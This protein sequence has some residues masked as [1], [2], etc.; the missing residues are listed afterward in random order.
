M[1]H[2]R[3]P[4]PAH[5]ARRS[6]RRSIPPRRRSGT[7]RL[8]T[9]DAGATLDQ[10]ATLVPLRRDAHD[11]PNVFDD[12]ANWWALARQCMV[13]L[14]RCMRS[15]SSTSTSSRTTS[16]FPARP[17]QAARPAAGQPLAPDIKALALIDVAFSLLPGVELPGALPVRGSPTTSTSRRASCRRS[18]KVVAA[19]SRRR[20][21]LDWRCDFFSLAATLWRYLPEFDDAPE[22][23]GRRA[24]RV[25]DQVRPPAARDPRRAGVGGAAA[26]RPDRPG[27][28]APRRP[29][30]RRGA[31]GGQQLRSGPLLAARRRGDAVDARRPTTCRGQREPEPAGAGRGAR[32]ARRRRSAS[33]GARPMVEPVE[34]ASNCRRRIRDAS[35]PGD[36]PAT[37]IA[38]GAK[39]RSTG[40]GA[41]NVAVAATGPRRRC[42]RDRCPRPHRHSRPRRAGSRGDCLFRVH[43]R[44]EALD[45]RRRH[46]AHR[47]RGSAVRGAGARAGERRR[48]ERIGTRPDSAARASPDGARGRRDRRPGRG[49]DRGAVALDRQIAGTR[50][51][52]GVPAAVGERG[53]VLPARSRRPRKGPLPPRRPARHAGRRRRHAPRRTIP[54]DDRPRAKAPRCC[55]P[56]GRAPTRPCCRRLPRRVP[57]TP[58]CRRLPCRAPRTPRWR[59]LSRRVPARPRSRRAPRRLRRQRCPLGAKAHRARPRRPRPAAARARRPTPAP[60][61]PAGDDLDALASDLLKNR[62]PTTALER[63]AA[64]RAGSRGRRRCERAAPPRRRSHG[65]AGDALAHSPKAPVRDAGAQ[66]TKRAA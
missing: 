24:P 38:S 3:P 1:P 32:T 45:R 42:R 28:A 10:W 34:P 62:I 46:G 21:Q 58:R 57:R 33:R 29:A 44:D 23:A 51:D 15:A 40:D 61:V 37:G 31:A 9:R 16:A 49:G 56:R 12:C 4:R 30:A 43:R 60:S 53:G 5:G 18:R 63:R 35:R 41:L 17:A 55:R 65:D 59:R 27:G 39:R 6:P 52:G 20:A 66:R 13:A 64:S 8:Q 25:G 2:P 19:A 48:G 54:L 22:P 11:L 26:P 50:D 7:A 36:A 47:D 14:E